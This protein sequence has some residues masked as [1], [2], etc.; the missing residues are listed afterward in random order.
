MQPFSEWLDNEFDRQAVEYR[1]ALQETVRIATTYTGI[2]GQGAI[3]IYIAALREVPRPAMNKYPGIATDEDKAGYAKHRKPDFNFML[4]MAI[5][6][7]SK[8]KSK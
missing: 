6:D 4:D 5:K 3:G 2:I 8:L 7:V 1:T